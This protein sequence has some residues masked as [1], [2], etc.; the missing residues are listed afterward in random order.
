MSRK[1]WSLDVSGFYGP[2]RPVTQTALP[3]YMEGYLK[4]GA[5][6]LFCPKAEMGLVFNIPGI[7]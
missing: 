2:P 5:V 7:Y 1:Y 6:S 4:E 3:L